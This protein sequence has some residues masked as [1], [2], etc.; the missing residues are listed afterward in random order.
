MDCIWNIDFK[1]PS[2]KS[3]DMNNSVILIQVSELNVL[4]FKNILIQAYHCD[5]LEQG[6]F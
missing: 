2:F 5:S 4:L 1:F 6:N 3:T